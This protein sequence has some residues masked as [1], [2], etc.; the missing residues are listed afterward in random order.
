MRS[1]EFSDVNMANLES[2]QVVRLLTALDINKL[3]K[4]ELKKALNM[5]LEEKK[6]ERNLQE[7]Y[8]II[9]MK[10]EEILTEIKDVKAERGAL[11]EKIEVLEIRKSALQETCKAQQKFSE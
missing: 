8:N 4:G 6:I 9:E 7:G 11:M 2:A 10:L 5:L 3:N 1:R